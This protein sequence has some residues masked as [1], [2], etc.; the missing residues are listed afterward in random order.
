[1]HHFIRVSIIRVWR[2]IWN[3]LAIRFAQEFLGVE[4]ERTFGESATLPDPLRIFDKMCSTWNLEFRH[5]FK[6]F[7]SGS[8]IYLLEEIVWNVYRHFRSMNFH[9]LF[10]HNCLLFYFSYWII[11]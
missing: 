5:G 2:E 8:G 9:H 11:E 1:M 3:I 7:R 4:G 6:F 10:Y